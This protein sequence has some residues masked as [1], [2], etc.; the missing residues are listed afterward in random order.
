MEAQALPLNNS[1]TIEI[2]DLVFQLAHITAPSWYMNPDLQAA[3]KD[4][5][6]YD[7][8][9]LCSPLSVSDGVHAALASTAPPSAPFFTPI[10]D[11]PARCWG[12]YGLWFEKFGHPPK[13]YIGSGTNVDY[14]VLVRLRLYKPGMHS[15]PRFVKKAFEDGFVITHRG[16]LC[17]VQM[18]SAALIPRL[19]ARMLLLETLL[20]VIFVACIA[21]S[22]DSFVADFVR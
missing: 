5:A 17:W 14:G 4:R 12:V 6:E 22:T 15:A 2:D 16:L 1:S 3:F 10:S 20:T 9:T 19:R 8:L 13:L 7:A 11:V 18:P 21:M